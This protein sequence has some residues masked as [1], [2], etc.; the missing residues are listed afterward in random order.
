MIFPFYV[1]PVFLD[2]WFPSVWRTF[3]FSCNSWY[4]GNIF[5]FHFVFTWESILHS[6][7]KDNFITYR[8]LKPCTS[9]FFFL[10]DIN[11][12]K[13]SPTIASQIT[14]F[15]FTSPSALPITLMLHLLI[16]SHFLF[17]LLFFFLYVSLKSFSWFIFQLLIAWPCPI[18]WSLFLLQYF[19][20]SF[21]LLS[22][23]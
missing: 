2:I 14:F 1:D 23:W 21:V 9:L 3:N 6:L 4:S 5:F 8:I 7:L 18:K 15:S 13:S 11:F 10:Y 17:F 16:L 20:F 19:Q 22:R 12:G